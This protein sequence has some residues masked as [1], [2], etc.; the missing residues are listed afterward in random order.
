MSVLIVE[1]INLVYTENN[2]E[3]EPANDG[4]IVRLLILDG[5]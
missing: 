3:S 4:D 2:V 5:C 1:R